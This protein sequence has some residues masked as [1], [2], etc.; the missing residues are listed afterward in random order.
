MAKCNQLT[1]VLFK[2][3]KQEICRRLLAA[4]KWQPWDAIQLL[5]NMSHVSNISRTVQHIHG[6]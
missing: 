3:L 1:H 6:N 5:H 2:E 4:S